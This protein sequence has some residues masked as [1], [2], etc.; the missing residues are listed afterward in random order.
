MA[1]FYFHRQKPRKHKFLTFAYDFRA[2]YMANICFHRQ[3]PRKRKFLSFAYDVRAFYKE[4]LLGHRK[5]LGKLGKLNFLTNL[6]QNFLKKRT[7]CQLSSEKKSGTVKSAQKIGVW[8]FWTMHTIFL[9]DLMKLGIRK[10]IGKSNISRQVGMLRGMPVGGCLI[11]GKIVT[12]I[13]KWANFL[14]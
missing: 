1:K 3:K 2:F 12:W 4:N 7:S 14:G 13:L 9:A 10:K 6:L 8:E 5:I 11:P